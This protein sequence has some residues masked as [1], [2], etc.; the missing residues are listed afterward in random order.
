VHGRALS[1]DGSTVYVVGEMQPASSTQKGTVRDAFIAVLDAT[2]LLTTKISYLGEGA[3]GVAY[4]V[5][6]SDNAVFVAYT[7]SSAITG[8]DLHLCKLNA[9]G[10]AS[11]EWAC[12]REVILQGNGQDVPVALALSQNNVVVIGTSDSTDLYH[13]GDGHH[14][15]EDII[16]GVYTRASLAQMSLQYLGGEATDRAGGVV[17][18]GDEITVVGTTN[19][20]EIA[21]TDS[22]RDTAPS[23]D[24]EGL[25]ARLALNGG[26]I[27]YM[28]LF[29]AHGADALTGVA[30]DPDSA[31]YCIGGA[32]ASG[33][34]SSGLPGL[35]Q[36]ELL[37]PSDAFV[38][39]LRLDSEHAFEVVWT[40]LV[41]GSGQETPGAVACAG[42]QTSIV[43]QTTS[44]DFPEK[45]LADTANQFP[46]DVNGDRP[47]DAFV[48]IILSEKENPQP[49]EVRASLNTSS[50][51]WTL[52]VSWDPFVD[53]SSV[54]YAVGV[55]AAD[56]DEPELLEYLDKN[57][58]TSHTFENFRAGMGT[59]IRAFVRA[60]DF[61]GNSTVARSDPIVVLSDSDGGLPDSGSADGGLPD[62]G[63]DAGALPHDAGIVDAG[64]DAGFDAGIDARPDAGDADAAPISARQA[65][66]GWGCSSAGGTAFIGLGTL[67]LA[68]LLGP[69]KRS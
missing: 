21:L 39:R 24:S 37:G 13:T 44:P 45:E 22:A 10:V 67:A 49:G 25:I 16:V 58:V 27:L 56:S 46:G 12:T 32:V 43:G 54:K 31:E 42:G 47:G 33:G 62:S 68:L 6:A 2:N 60:T 63:H 69:R 66:L 28:S 20:E 4:A 14:G 48:A 19:S 30:Y 51:E 50:S 53:A 7:T 40:A 29:G 18:V 61:F 8:N 55:G 11:D 38:S 17:I 57:Q 9:S 65:V 15:D 5:A 52:D 23:G 34:T 64:F 35:F 41:G 59:T 36:D 3:Q 26:D 1:N